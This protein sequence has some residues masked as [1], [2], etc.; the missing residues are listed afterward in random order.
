MCGP[1]VTYGSSLTERHHVKYIDA[2]WNR[3]TKL[4]KKKIEW[5]IWTGCFWLKVGTRCV[6]L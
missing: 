6:L 2:Y 4:I 5:E 1:R 3:I